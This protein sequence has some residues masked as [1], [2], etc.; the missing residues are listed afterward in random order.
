MSEKIDII[1]VHLEM[2][3]LAINYLIEN[4]ICH[5][6]KINNQKPQ[7]ECYDTD[8]C[9]ASLFDGLKEMSE[10]RIY[11]TARRTKANNLVRKKRF[12]QY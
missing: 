1:N 12:N 5:A 2:I 10:G 3:D 11:E 8:L 4:D 7:Q 6:C 9:K